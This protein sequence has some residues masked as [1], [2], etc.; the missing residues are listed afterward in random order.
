MSTHLILDDFATA[1]ELAAVR[2]QWP[3]ADWPGWV[4]YDPATQ[5]KHA[6]DPR[7][8]LPLPAARLLQ[9]MA[10]L[11]LPSWLGKSLIPDLGLWGAGLHA[12]PPGPGLA[13][14]V[15]AGQHALLGLA[16]VLSAVLY[17][18]DDWHDRWGGELHLPGLCVTPRPGRLLVFDCRGLLHSVAPVT[19]PVGFARRSLALFWYGSAAEG[20]PTRAQFV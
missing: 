7:S 18:H 15:D 13:P 19:C 9:R 14:H 5:C 2:E 6:S 17:V 4:H 16:R 8:R 12:M 20:L 10:A 11:P 3:A 1:E